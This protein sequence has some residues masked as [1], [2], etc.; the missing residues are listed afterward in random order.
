M[1]GFSKWMKSISAAD[2]LSSVA[3]ASLRVRLQGVSHFLPLAANEPG[4]N[5]EHVHQLRV[6]TRRAAAALYLFQA[7]T[8]PKKRKQMR[9]LLGEVRRAAGPARDADVLI[10]RLQQEP[11]NP[12]A[13]YAVG[14]L[15]E[16]RR[17]AQPAIVAAYEHLARG[18]RFRR[19]VKKLVVATERGVGGDD[20]RFGKW[21]RRR[22]RPIVT[23]FFQAAES[24]FA[25]N[26]QLHQF[27]IRGKRL[28]YA[29]E[30]LSPAFDSEFRNQL[31]PV[32]STLQDLLGDL[33]NFVVATE[34]FQAWLCAAGNPVEGKLI[35]RL[36]SAEEE[37]QQQ[38][39]QEFFDWWTPNRQR[40][41]RQEFAAHAGKRSGKAA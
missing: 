12:A 20:P 29:M 24:D 16:E 27:R 33:N 37:R 25:E 38:A 17:A 3:A 34:R 19:R 40:Q 21:A 28:R 5:I 23:D 10:E 36:V 14:R 35:K 4:A 13:Q 30:L 9:R 32:V 1:T 2:R 39:R 31:Y 15:T 26:E 7:A 8:P 22:L 18:G 41:L 6:W 11:E